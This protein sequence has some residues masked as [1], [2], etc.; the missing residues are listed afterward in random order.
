VRSLSKNSKYGIRVW[1]QSSCWAGEFQSDLGEDNG[2]RSRRECRKEP[3]LLG[4]WSDDWILMMAS[5]WRQTQSETL[6]F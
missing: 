6:E 1:A 2:K 4:W 3:C 5:S